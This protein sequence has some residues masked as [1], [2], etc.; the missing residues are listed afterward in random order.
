[1]PD[2]IGNVE[3]VRKLLSV[4]TWKKIVQLTLFIFIIGISWASYENRE[5]IY[6]FANQKRLDPRTPKLIA[7][8]KTTV[9]QINVYTDK[10]DIIIGIRI[11]IANFQRNTRILIYQHVN[12]TNLKDV[13]AID[14]KSALSE[15]PLFTNDVANNKNLVSLINGEFVCI[16]YTETILS[17]YAPMGAA[18]T[19]QVCANG[20]PASYGRFTG[21]ISVHLKRIPTP[22]EIDQIR[23]LTRSMSTIIYEEDLSKIVRYD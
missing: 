6:G 16:P 19:K 1:M 20:I 8:S 2:V 4:L 13:L 22:E 17:K 23:T 21:I 14:E 12:D 18:Y 3:A 9:A 11:Y 10:S 7:L 15:L 5:T